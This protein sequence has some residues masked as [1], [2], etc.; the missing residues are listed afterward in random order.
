M[1]I[2]IAYEQGKLK[3]FMLLMDKESSKH[4][5][6]KALENEIIASCEIEGEILNRQ[7]VRSSIKQKL[8]LESQQ[9]YKA[10]KKEDNY[11][12]ILIDAN[13]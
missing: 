6:A 3:S 1:L 5:I 2:D 12:D 10:L 8:G 9:H 4:S 13:T 7:S 11:V